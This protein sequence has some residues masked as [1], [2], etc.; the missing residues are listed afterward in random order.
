MSLYLISFFS[1]HPCM[2]HSAG[3]GESESPWLMEC[4]MAQLFDWNARGSYESLKL[5]ASRWLSSLRFL[6][7]LKIT[8]EKRC[9]LDPFKLESEFEILKKHF[10]YSRSFHTAGVPCY[11]SLATPMKKERPINIP[12]DILSKKVLNWWGM[13]LAHG[14]TDLTRTKPYGYPAYSSCFC[15][16]S[17][18]P[19]TIRPSNLSVCLAFTFVSC[20]SCKTCHFLP[21]SWRS[22]S[23]VKRIMVNM[24]YPSRSKHVRRPFAGSPAF[25]VFF[26]FHVCKCL[27]FF[28]ETAS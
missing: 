18:A 6:S 7:K 22:K 8:R 4:K 19:Q 10:P 16:Q 14:Y 28:N 24:Y 2:K 20:I 26:G 17:F 23:I 12:K 21:R 1:Q 25:Y 9:E 13:I 11:E 5:S 27:Q 3:W 15:A